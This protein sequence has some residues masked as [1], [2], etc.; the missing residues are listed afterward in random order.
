MR[1]FTE[2]PELQAFLVVF[3]WGVNVV[4]MKMGINDMSPVLYTAIRFSIVTLLLLPFCKVPRDQMV[5]VA[6]IALIMGVG[7]FCVLSI[8]ISYV[9]SAVV[10]L[11]LLLGA[12]FSSLLAFIFIGERLSYKQMLL[13]LIAMSGAC[14]PTLIE[15]QIDAQIGC[16][17]VLLSMLTWA[18]G[19]LMIRRV[20]GLPTLT[21]QFWIG[22]LS[23]PICFALYH[24]NPPA[25][26][27]A[28]QI[29]LTSAASLVYV[30]C[31][32]SILG[33]AIWYK[34]IRNHGVNRI[35]NL[36]LLQPVITL[37]AGYL[38]LG[39]VLSLNQQVGAGIMILSMFYFLRLERRKQAKG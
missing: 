7:H 12:P 4:V 38:L 1:S 22:A 19:N 17:I 3:L 37:I 30:V 36:V 33:Y 2:Q 28:E 8:G 34:L 35:V 10:G 11:I 21:V 29:T 26:S 5:S 24:L 13:I 27:V 9:E 16:L 15:N 14:I 31:C 25:A 6:L 23:A 20:S 18:I 39:E 32:S